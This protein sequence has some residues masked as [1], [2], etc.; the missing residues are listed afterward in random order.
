MIM[1]AER[2]RKR[3]CLGIAGLA[4]ALYAAMAIKRMLDDPA[5]WLDEAFVAHTL[6]YESLTTF[7][8]KPMVA[9]FPRAYLAAIELLETVFG[10]STRVIR[11]LPCLAALAAT[12]AMVR[13]L[14]ELSGFRPWMTAMGAGLV[15]LNQEWVFQAVNLKPYTLDTLLSVA[16]FGLR[17]TWL[18]ET[19][20]ERGKKSRLAVLVL[21]T[22]FSYVYPLSLIARI[23]SWLWM[24]PR[25]G[26]DEPRDRRFQWKRIAALT[27]GL[28]TALAILAYTD[29]RFTRAS[30]MEGFWKG[31]ILRHALGEP[32][33]ALELIGDFLFGWYRYNFVEPWVSLGIGAVI[34]GLGAT[35]W[36]D[37][38]PGW[39]RQPPA[40][41]IQT[42]RPA[43]D[44]RFL[45]AAVGLLGVI[46]ASIAV[47]WPLDAFRLTLFSAVFSYALA[48]RG[49]A[50][51]RQLAARPGKRRLP[52]ALVQLA[53]AGVLV[54]LLIVIVHRYEQYFRGRTPGDARLYLAAVDA[55]ISDTL[56]VLPCSRYQIDTLPEALPVR[57]LIMSTGSVEKDLEVLR[58]HGRVW[59]IWLHA[60]D[61]EALRLEEY[62]SAATFWKTQLSASPSEGIAL[63]EFRA[64]SK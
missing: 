64:P 36:R 17:D 6:H 56:F 45:A 30:A 23:T 53:A 62:R 52:A 47:S 27:M 26:V 14:A 55:R 32:G 7:F 8:K 15:L 60:R 40:E 33:R 11:L 63:V 3:L 54:W 4:L 1:D 57:G 29:Y 10:Y 28:G 16:V 18:D 46:L 2:R 43:R 42:S 49:F 38:K 39:L 58:Q 13:L 61:S 22:L 25:E 21:P 44:S 12:Y 19:F 24:R 9:P 51:V 31:K 20:A 37:A 34:L 48:L 59:A 5:F 50:V 35:L 41:S